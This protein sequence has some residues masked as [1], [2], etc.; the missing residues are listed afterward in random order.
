MAEDKAIETSAAK[1]LRYAK[2]EELSTM[3][4]EILGVN[5]ELHKANTELDLLEDALKQ[6]EYTKNAYDEKSGNVRKRMQ[7]VVTRL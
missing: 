5:N 2:A 1:D 3:T 7:R 6:L 4:E